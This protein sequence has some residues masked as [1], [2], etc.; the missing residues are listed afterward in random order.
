MYIQIQFINFSHFF[1]FLL[2]YSLLFFRFL[3]LSLLSLLWIL[4]DEGGAGS[5]VGIA[6]DIVARFVLC[7]VGVFLLTLFELS[8]LNAFDVNGRLPLHLRF[9]CFASLPRTVSRVK[10][11]REKCLTLVPPFTWSVTPDAGPPFPTAHLFRN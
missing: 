11:F 2:L 3:F 1:S 7:D 6:D 4:R 5:G 10:E 9:A 8:L